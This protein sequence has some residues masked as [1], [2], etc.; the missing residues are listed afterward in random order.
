M[1]TANKEV[2]KN[3]FRRHY[4]LST[5]GGIFILLMIIG[6]IGGSK[7]P[8]STSLATGESNTSNPNPQ[9]VQPAQ[10]AIKVTAVDLG[11]AYKANEV[12]AD[13]KYKGNL[14]QVSGIVNTIGKDITSTP[15]ITLKIDEYGIS[16]VQCMFSKDSE[17]QLAQISKDTSITLQGTVSGYTIGNVLVRDCQIV[18]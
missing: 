8:S 10:S 14:V 16:S 15:Y 12:A 7:T 6:S 1:D 17:N 11:G 4:I 2:R 3:W 9:P 5:I 13:A 18:K